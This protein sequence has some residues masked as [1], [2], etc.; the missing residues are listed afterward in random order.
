MFIERA[1]KLRRSLT[2]SLSLSHTHTH[3]LS[4]SLSHTH[5]RTLSRL[6]TTNSLLLSFS[7]SP[8]LDLNISHFTAITTFDLFCL[9]TSFYHLNQKLFPTTLRLPSLPSPN[10][11]SP[12]HWLT[13]LMSN[14][15]YLSLS[16]ISIRVTLAIENAS[17]PT[18]KRTEECLAEVA[19]Y[20]AHF[21]LKGLA[22]NSKK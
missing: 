17:M 4:L 7:L 6:K 3:A 21:S 22:L 1:L 16:L 12:S 19:Q 5:A 15:A 13:I 8:T 10:K 2:L 20:E 18:F 11:S 9:F 14:S